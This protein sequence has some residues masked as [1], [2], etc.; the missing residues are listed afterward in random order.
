MQ[1]KKWYNC[2]NL[3]IHSVIIRIAMSLKSIY[4]NAKVSS[5]LFSYYKT[6]RLGL[7]WGFEER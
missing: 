2:C 3:S 1:I 6:V 5:V 4:N 7:A